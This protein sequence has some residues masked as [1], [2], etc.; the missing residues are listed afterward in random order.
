MFYFLFNVATHSL[1]VHN[2]VLSLM[3]LTPFFG[4]N[5]LFIFDSSSEL[6]PHDPNYD[7]VNHSFSLALGFRGTTYDLL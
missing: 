7:L 3:F 6:E 4:E 2:F 1:L 5:P